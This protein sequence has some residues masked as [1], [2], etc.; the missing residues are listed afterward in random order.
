MSAK[1]SNYYIIVILAMMTTTQ[2]R[3]ASTIAAIDRSRQ[4]FPTR[5]FSGFGSL[6]QT[7]NIMNPIR[8]LKNEIIYRIYFSAPSGSCGGA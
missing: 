5:L 1:V 4:F 8:M 6:F 3:T 2:H 7:R